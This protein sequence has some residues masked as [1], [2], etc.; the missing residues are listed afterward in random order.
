MPGYSDFDFQNPSPGM[1]PTGFGKRKLPPVPAIIA[2]VVLG[3]GAYVWF[4]LPS[5]EPPRQQVPVDEPAKPAAAAPVVVAKPPELPALDDSD[6]FVRERISTLSSNPLLATWLKTN[7][8]AR[9][10][11]VVLENTARGLTPSK[12][13]IALKPTGVF[14]VVRERNRIILDPLNYGRFTDIV[15]ATGSIDPKVAAT[16]YAALKPLL[17]VAYDELGNQEA[18][19]VALERAL[20][21]LLG[22]PIIEG[23]IPVEIGEK[24]VG[25]R[26][27][28]T[29]LENLTGAQ[30]QLV[31][32]GP[33]NMRVI[34][35]RL[36]LLALALGIQSTRLPAP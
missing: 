8:L 1:P 15:D 22:A 27:V 20:I 12:H 26:F 31:R 16:V 6:T 36:R 9:N 14:R 24:G 4:G 23:D 21:G 29:R 19:D 28:E 11:A 10:L 7:G 17:Q 13:L 25:Y 34:Q 3:F 2:V 30:K 33:A 5:T 18:I 32:M 35:G